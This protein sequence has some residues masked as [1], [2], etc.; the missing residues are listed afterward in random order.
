MIQTPAKRMSAALKLELVP[1][2]KARGFVGQFPRFRRDRPGTVQ[3]LAIFYDKDATRFFLEFGSHERG[4]KTTSW[5]EVVPECKLV[6]EHVRFD[7]RARLQARCEGGSLAADWF[8]FGAFLE[9]SEFRSL[10]ASVSKLLPQVEAWLESGIVSPNVSP[11]K[12]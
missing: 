6:L 9:D 3:F 4:D 8:A 5:G 2:L 7:H 11:N 10:A 1:A 12:P